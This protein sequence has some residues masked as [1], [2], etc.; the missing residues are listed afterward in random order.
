MAAGGLDEE[1]GTWRGSRDGG[2]GDGA[3]DDEEE[4]A[5]LGAPKKF[6][7]EGWPLLSPFLIPL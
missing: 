7:I 6:M 5:A 4:E 2:G 3:D 1:E